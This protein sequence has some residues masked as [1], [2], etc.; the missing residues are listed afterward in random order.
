MLL[1]REMGRGLPARTPRPQWSARFVGLW[2]LCSA[3]SMA[4]I[5]CEELWRGST[6]LGVHSG[7][8]QIASAGGWSSIP[9]AVFV[10]LFLA[11]SLRYARW[12][13]RAVADWLRPHLA[14]V[15][16]STTGVIRS[17][18]AQQPQLAPVADGWSSR[19][20]PLRVSVAANLS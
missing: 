11:A 19:G 12:A 16:A 4:C 8:V 6:S 20:T 14:G 15:S 18:L 13:A 17:A 2:V 10:G 9:A 7:L 3:I 1:L 5:S